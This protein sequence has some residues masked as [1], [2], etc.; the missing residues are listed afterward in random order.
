MERELPE[1]VE[2]VIVRGVKKAV[3]DQAPSVRASALNAIAS[4]VPR[5]GPLVLA[6]IW[7]GAERASCLCRRT[8]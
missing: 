5:A 1:D 2:L 8:S 3:R 6:E 4:L 7:F